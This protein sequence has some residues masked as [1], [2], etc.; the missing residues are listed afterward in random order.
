[1]IQNKAEKL[2]FGA[3]GAAN[4]TIDVAVLFLLS[5]WGLPAVA[6]NIVSTSLA[7]SFSF[8]ANKHYTF[9][10]HGSANIR[11][12]IALFVAVTLIGLWV[13]QSVVM[14]VFLSVVNRP[15]ADGLTLLAAKVL[16]TIVSLTWNYILYSR[17]VFKGRAGDAT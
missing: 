11:R 13:W 8:F 12:E 15:P 9:K 7:F 1:M 17:L 6:A 5:A 2:R 16:A 14:Y 4:T 10:A 3:V